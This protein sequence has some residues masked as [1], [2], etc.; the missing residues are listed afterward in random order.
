MTLGQ[1]APFAFAVENASYVLS[2]GANLIEGWGAPVRMQAAYRLWRQGNGSKQATKLVQVDSRCSMSAAKADQWVAVAPGMEAALALGIAHILVKENLYDSN[3]VQDNVFGFEDWKDAQG[4]TR[5]GFK[6]LILSAEYTPEE[7]AKKAG[8]EASKI[9]ELAKEF[10]AADRAVVVWGQNQG[11]LPGNIY[12]DL[13]FIAL[14]ALKGSLGSGGTVSLVPG[15]PFEPLPD[16]HMD[17]AATHALEQQRLDRQ[18]SPRVPLA[19]NGVYAFLDVV[20]KGGA[21][22]DQCVDGP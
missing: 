7:I 10:A 21:L 22:P 13:S 3:F 11:D 14:N 9:R 12:D 16:L 20:S 19:G 6:N 15:V 5:R 1:Q 17:E 2:F 4:K 18:Q 8:V